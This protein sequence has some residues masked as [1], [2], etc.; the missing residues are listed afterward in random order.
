MADLTA[1][2][3]ELQMVD[4]GDMLL[5]EMDPVDEKSEVV[6]ITPDDGAEAREAEPLADDCQLTSS[7][8]M[9]TSC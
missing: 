9:Q 5:D 3:G 6:N 7:I 2:L 8:V 1:H 4:G